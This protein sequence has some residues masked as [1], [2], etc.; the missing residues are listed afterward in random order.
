[1][2]EGGG[3]GP[4]RWPPRGA[5]SGGAEPSSYHQATNRPAAT[6]AGPR[7]RRSLKLFFVLRMFGAEALR[8]YVRH[9]VALAGW[10][11]ERVQVG[12]L[13]PYTP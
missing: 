8:G 7:G 11:A 5:D 6:A 9:H 10:L 3:E 13:E 2:R 1:M 4:T 12:P